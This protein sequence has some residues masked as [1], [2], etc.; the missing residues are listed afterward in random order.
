MNSMRNFYDVIVIGGGHAG[1]EA[2]LASARSGA[3]TL[4]LTQNIETLGQMSCNPAI[5]GIGKSHLVKEVDALGGMMALVTDDAGIQFRR[6]NTSRGAAVQATRAQCDRALYKMAVRHYLNASENLYLL[7]ETVEDL[8]VEGE[9]VIGV[10]AS[11]GRRL[12]A[13]AVVLTAGTFLNGLMHIG[14]QKT[15][16]GRA[17]CA[18][19]TDLA[20]RLA[21]LALPR[22]RLKTGTPARLDGR[23][24]NF[25][26]LQVQ[27]GDTPLPVMS[28]IGDV[29]RHPQQRCCHITATTAQTHDIIRR[30]LHESP[31]F[32]GEIEGTGPRYC[33]SIEDK[34]YRF[35]ERDSHRV[36][37]EPE[38]LQVA[39]YYPN[40]ISTSL[41]GNVQEEFIR[42]I[43][44]LEQVHITRPGYAIEYD[45]FDPRALLPSLQTRAL[46]GLYFAGQI[47]GTT[48]YEEAAAQ[49]LIAGLNAARATQQ[50]EPWTPARH[51]AYIGVLIDDLTSRG[52][53]EP[54]RMFTSRAE[55]RLTL[56]EDNADLRLTE[57]GRSLNL[58]DDARYH[59]FT[60]RRERLAQEEERL[61][62]L[63][64][65]R[66]CATAEAGVSFAKWL[67]RSD[68]RYRDLAEAA[69][70]TAATDIAEIEARIKYAGYIN[71]QQN[72]L[73]QAQQEDG[74]TIPKDFDFTGVSGLSMEVRELLHRYH[75]A[76]V[77]QARRISGMT[78]AALSLLSAHL[79]KTAMQ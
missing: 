73:A 12:Q 58:V 5:G 51:E 66:V 22:G 18:A 71:H 28:F 65:D 60:A 16:G 20:A 10:K 4:L 49:G 44:G 50:L 9:A 27:P 15:A 46:S 6:L 56:R 47:N 7:Q 41:P 37:L 8:L 32:S 17:G 35:S 70:L 43:P 13:A 42:T 40:G 79:K 38:G 55:C 48:G 67:R 1:C 34:V 75:P 78:P 33:P 53:V 64:A 29:S 14:Q 30:H 63:P 21:E 76:N 26:K 25:E 45:Y 11:D 23:T 74:M 39:E 72:Q 52:V 24:I 57:I 54:Y 3:C 69:T 77:R 2:A 31:L 19:A 68:A 62:T 59:S 36:F 61:T